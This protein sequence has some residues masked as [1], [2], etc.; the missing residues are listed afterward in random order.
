MMQLTLEGRRALIT[1]S[2]RGIGRAIALAFAQAGADV[3][4]TA[5]SEGEI[6]HVADEVKSMGC[7]GV[8]ITCDVANPDDIT[9]MAAQV[10]EALGGVDILVNNAGMAASHKML[11]HPDELWHQVMAVNLNSVYYVTKAL[12]PTL[13]ER[14]GGRIINIASIAS[15]VG[16][17]YTTRCWG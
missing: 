14:K 6:T 12:L 5:R 10:V 16:S 17:R 13:I 11:G 1:G 3:A 4:V 7:R 9:R 8:A 2:G 15:K